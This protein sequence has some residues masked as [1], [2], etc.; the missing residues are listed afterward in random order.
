MSSRNI[1]Y[2]NRNWLADEWEP[3]APQCGNVLVGGPSTA[4]LVVTA[5]SRR[6]NTAGYLI[7]NRV[8]VTME[9]ES[10]RVDPTWNHNTTLTRVIRDTPGDLAA[11]ASVFLRAFAYESAKTIGERS[12]F[13]F[14]AKYSNVTFSGTAIF[15]PGGEPFMKFAYGPF[16][17]PYVGVYGDVFNYE[18]T[19]MIE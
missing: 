9:R 7:I 4:S 3:V 10:L 2:L 1:S 16:V 8:D 19:E 13:R 6:P 11:G 17:I 5:A 18:W 12:G 15:G 14:Q